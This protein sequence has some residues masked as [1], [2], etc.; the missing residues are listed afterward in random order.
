MSQI[1][2]ERCREEESD[3]G[4]RVITRGSRVRVR[5]RRLLLATAN[6]KRMLITAPRLPL[7]SECQAAVV[8]EGFRSGFSAGS[9]GEWRQGLINTERKLHA[10]KAA[11]RHGASRAYARFRAHATG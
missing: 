3:K 5:I 8:L 10:I 2:G 4:I 6:G 1:S 11:S 7:M 9:R